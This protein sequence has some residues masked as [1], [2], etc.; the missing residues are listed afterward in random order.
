MW[1]SGRRSLASEE[2]SRIE[3]P[4]GWMCEIDWITEES[5]FLKIQLPRDLLPEFDRAWYFLPAEPKRY[6]TRGGREVVEGRLTV[7]FGQP[8]NY[9]GHKHPAA[10][11]PQMVRELQQLLCNLGLGYYDETLLNG[12]IDG[13]KRIIR[14]SDDE[15]QIVPRSNIASL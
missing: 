9:G 7:S 8:Y 14:H 3:V 1:K 12:Y 11:T 5:W 15:V 6:R 10:W 2:V 4:M 13:S